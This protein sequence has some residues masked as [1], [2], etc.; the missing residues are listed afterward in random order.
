[1]KTIWPLIK[2][3]FL[4]IFVIHVGWFLY[5]V[6]TNFS[7]AI[8]V[9]EFKWQLLIA[10]GIACL[11]VIVYFIW[12]KKNNPI[13]K[14]VSLTWRIFFTAYI[15][16]FFYFLLGFVFNPPITLTQLGSVL[17][18]NG[19]SRDYISYDAM[20]SNIKLAVIA[21]EDQ[22]FPDHDGFDLKA[23]KLAMKYNK[24]HPGKIRGGSTIS[25][26]TAKNIFLFQGGGFIRKG[27]EVFFTFTIET[28]WSKRKILE[29]YLNIAE[30]GRGI[31]GVQAAAK[32]YFNKDAKD[33]TRGEAAQIAACL[34]NPKKYTVK[35]LS[36][37]VANRYD[38]IM[39]QM[40]NLEGDP[41][42]EEIIK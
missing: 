40:N 27:P 31:F 10:M 21:S 29:R 20:G 1:M 37:Y 33:L 16:Y 14:A 39:R 35:P 23:I 13:K 8:A 6:F 36:N 34:P 11:L 25:Q 7:D 30:M 42:I 41:D 28:A 18:G 22:R 19:L 4:V 5:F 38:D 12:L 15:L 9:K 17:Q 26:Q 32:K 2:K 24:R 3:L